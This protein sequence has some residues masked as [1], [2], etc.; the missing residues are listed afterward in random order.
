MVKLLT[1]AYWSPS[2]IVSVPRVMMNPLSPVATTRKPLTAPIRV[3]A[4]NPASS[5]TQIGALRATI[6]CAMMAADAPPIAPTARFNWPT[7]STTI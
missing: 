7:E 1:S 3:A 2:I 6:I 5:A 4:R